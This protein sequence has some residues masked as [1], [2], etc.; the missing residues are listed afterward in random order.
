MEPSNSDWIAP[1]RAI[2]SSEIICKNSNN[3]VYQE[4]V[5]DIFVYRL[6]SEF[7]S[8]CFHRLKG[9]IMILR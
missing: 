2:F 7:I 8:N 5:T 4:D 1:R 9:D 3:G 6:Y